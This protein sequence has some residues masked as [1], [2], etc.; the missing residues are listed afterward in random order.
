[1]EV[2]RGRRVLVTGTTGFKGAWL[3]ELLLARG[4]E[5]VGIGLAPED[6]DAL[7]VLLGL[8]ERIEEQLIDLR[9]PDALK[10]AVTQAGPDVVIH[11]A[12]QA[13]VRRGHADPIGTWHTNVLGTVHLLEAV[14]ATP[15]V[16]AVLVATTDKVYAGDHAAP[17]RETDPLGGRCP[18]SASKVA[19][20]QAVLDARHRWARGRGLGLATARAG[21]TLGGGDLAADRLVPDCVRAVRAGT[22]LSLRSPQAVR[23][24]LHVLDVLDGYVRLADAL[25]ATPGTWETVNLGPTREGFDLTVEAVARAVL[26][27]LG[28][29]EALVVGPSDG[30]AER[31]VLRLDASRAAELGWAP[32]LSTAEALRWTADW[33]AAWLGGADPLSLCRQQ[34]AEWDALQA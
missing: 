5:V 25:A 3:A 28:Q 21:N 24:W 29:P 4:A 7:S 11:L 26:A 30:P 17:H 19:A 12:A 6:G 2:W 23:P 8:S 1:M 9:D 18:Y 27:G 14:R 20:E 34:I 15:S 13:L 16:R 32:R 22:A 31:Q 10:N 33:Y